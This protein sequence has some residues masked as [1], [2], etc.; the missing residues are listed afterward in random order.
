LIVG[1]I[2]ALLVG[3]GNQETGEAPT[4]PPPSL[5]VNRAVQAVVE[6]TVRPVL[7]LTRT[8]PAATPSAQRPD[9]PTT[10]PPVYATPTP[11]VLGRLFNANLDIMAGAVEVPLEIQIP[12]LKVNA[13][14]LGVGLTAARVMDAP[15][16]AVGDPIWGTAFWYRG[17][18]NPGENG[19]ATIAGH[20]NDPLGRPQIFAN[21]RE[22]RPGDLIIIHVKYVGIDLR[23]IVDQMKV[24]SNKDSSDPAVLALIYGAGPVSGNGPLPAP[25]GLSHLTLIT[26]AGNYTNGQFEHHT[27]VYA[28]IS[29]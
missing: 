1:V 6:P 21:L 15:T 10:L 3:C 19:T 28:T 17:S 4:G 27:V 2:A 14:V 18:G 13:P 29:P 16:G 11:F 25:D 22:L 9:L 26:C 23:F 7:Q 20:V 24:Y 5:T 12:A 8:E